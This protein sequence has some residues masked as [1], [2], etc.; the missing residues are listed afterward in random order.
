MENDTTEVSKVLSIYSDKELAL[1][2]DANTSYKKSL[3]NKGKKINPKIVK[4]IQDINALIQEQ[5]DTGYLSCRVNI[6]SKA[7]VDFLSFRGYVVTPIFKDT[8]FSKYNAGF[9]IS[10]DI[11]NK[12]FKK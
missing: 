11:K 7:A 12:P 2:E 5:I 1:L 3:E 8:G 9:L 4:E 6:I 10:W